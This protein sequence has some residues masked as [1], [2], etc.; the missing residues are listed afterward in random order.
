MACSLSLFLYF[1]VKTMFYISPW[2]PRAPLPLLPPSDGL[3]SGGL[4]VF[5][6]VQIY[7]GSRGYTEREREDV[8]G[9]CVCVFVCNGKTHAATPDLRRGWF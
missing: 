2:F 5:L 4:C 9:G 8:G 1:V 7:L 6:A 3:C